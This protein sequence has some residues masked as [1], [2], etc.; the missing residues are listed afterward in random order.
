LDRR[1]FHERLVPAEGERDRITL[2]HEKIDL[3]NLLLEDSE[4]G[5]V[6]GLHRQKQ[7]ILIPLFPDHF[8]LDRFGLLAESLGAKPF[9]QNRGDE[10][11]AIDRSGD[12]DRDSTDEDQDNQPGL[13]LGSPSVSSGWIGRGKGARESRHA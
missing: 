7:P 12:A 9:G 8:P 2:L 13:H 3:R 10:A 4:K 11:R 6:R 5:S 1:V